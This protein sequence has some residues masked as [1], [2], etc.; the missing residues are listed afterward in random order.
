MEDLT[1]KSMLRFQLILVLLLAMVMVIGAVAACG[2]DDD[3]DDNDDVTDDDDTTGG[4][5]D[6]TTGDDDDN[7]DDDT[8][9]EVA[10]IRVLHLSPNA[11]V[12]DVWVDNTVEFVAD[13]D[14]TEGS[15]YGEVPADDYTINIVPDGG[16]PATDSAL[17]IPV[18]LEAGKIYTAVVYGELAISKEGSGLATWLI[19]DDAN[20]AEDLENLILFVGHA[21]DA[22]TLDGVD[23]WAIVE[24]DDDLALIAD[25][26]YG[27]GEFFELAPGSYNLG[28]DLDEDNSAYDLTFTTPDLAGGAQYNVFAVYDDPNIFLLAQLPDGTTLRIDPDM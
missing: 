24:G 4:D 11:G 15:T 23:V 12:V 1:M 19:V 25:F 18:T 14:F 7:D 28:F 22:A 13:L 16:D 8:A 17:D 5:D 26:P 6:D 3:D 21:A 20:V 2:D 9:P 10:Y 27:G